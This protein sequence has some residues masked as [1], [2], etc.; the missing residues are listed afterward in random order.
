MLGSQ[1]VSTSPGSFLPK[2]HTPSRTRPAGL[3]PIAVVMAG[4]G[5]GA[6]RALDAAGPGRTL[7]FPNCSYG[8]DLNN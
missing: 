7:K 8:Q 1:E 4:E 6:L 2:L 5:G 3:C